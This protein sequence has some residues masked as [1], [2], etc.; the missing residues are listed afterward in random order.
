[1]SLVA[2]A[3]VLQELGRTD[4]AA[5]AMGKAIAVHEAKG[6]VI[7]AAATRRKLEDFEAVASKRGPMAN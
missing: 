1:M 5:E 7:S 4:Q 6:Y 2:L 3:E